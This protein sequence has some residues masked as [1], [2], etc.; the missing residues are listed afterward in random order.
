MM[1]AQDAK[2]TTI[3]AIQRKTDELIYN[4]YTKAIKERIQKGFYSGSTVIKDSETYD[5]N[6]IR[7]LFERKGYK[8]LIVYENEADTRISLF[9][10]IEQENQMG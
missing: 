6:R 3:T 10:N 9:W 1:N 5:L 4:I 2:N 8:V 7:D